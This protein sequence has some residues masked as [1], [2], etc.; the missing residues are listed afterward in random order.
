MLAFLADESVLF[1]DFFHNFEDVDCFQEIGF[2]IVWESH[3][4]DVV[5]EMGDPLCIF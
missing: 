4:E 2:F 1:S 5:L 3:V